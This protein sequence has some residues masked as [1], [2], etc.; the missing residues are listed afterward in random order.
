M[1]NNVLRG[2]IVQK[3]GSLKNFVEPV[4][5]SYASILAKISGS[6]D[7]TASEVQRICRLLE[8]QP[9]EIPDY[10]FTQEV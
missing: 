2:R 4:G 5:L 3:Y 1:Y 10:F 8:I 9:K 7:W 6:T